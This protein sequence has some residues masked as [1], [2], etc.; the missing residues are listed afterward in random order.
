MIGI[1]TSID[2]KKESEERSKKEIMERK[3]GK[4]KF[5]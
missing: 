5:I 1:L 3:K 4:V 2:D